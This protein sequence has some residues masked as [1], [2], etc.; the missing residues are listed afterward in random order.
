[1]QAPVAMRPPAN[2]PVSCPP[3]VAPSHH[4]LITSTPMPSPI[5]P[6]GAPTTSSFSVSGFQA[7]ITPQVMDH[8]DIEVGQ[9]LVDTTDDTEDTQ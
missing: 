7:D 8:E 5:F 2:R 3:D 9:N 1:V 6:N 4:A